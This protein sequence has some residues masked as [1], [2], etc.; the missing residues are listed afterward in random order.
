MKYL[1]DPRFLPMLLI[2]IDF[3]AGVAYLVSGDLKRG[4]YWWAAAVLTT[5]V[6]F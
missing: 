4:I 6:T 3:C 1:N 5:T 2:F